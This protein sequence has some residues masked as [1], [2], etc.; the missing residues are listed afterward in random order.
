MSG[1]EITTAAQEQLPVVMII[2]NDS[3]Y[4]MVM[5]GQRLGGAERIGYQLN[6]VNYA[7][8][9]EAMGVEGILIETAEQMEAI[10]FERLFKKDGPTLIDVRIDAEEVPPM[11]AR[12]KDLAAG[13]SATPGG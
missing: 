8:M 5:H 4:G 3:V 10:D 7:A 13:D 12:V 2:L 1:Q 11:G 9:A 6:K